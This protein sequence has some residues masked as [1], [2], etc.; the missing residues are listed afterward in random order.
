M[1]T[2]VVILVAKCTNW[3]T[4]E[5]KQGRVQFTVLQRKTQNIHGL[6]AKANIMYLKA[7]TVLDILRVFKER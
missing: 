7:L 6:A 5:L 2:F 3:E 1:K 4:L